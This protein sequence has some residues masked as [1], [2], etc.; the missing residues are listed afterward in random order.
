MVDY[1][2]AIQSIDVSKVRIIKKL[3]I[4]VVYNP[5][6]NNTSVSASNPAMWIRFIPLCAFELTM[7]FWEANE[8][9]DT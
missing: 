9:V 8:V 2:T 1:L 7:V 5:H 6:G 4:Q 3:I